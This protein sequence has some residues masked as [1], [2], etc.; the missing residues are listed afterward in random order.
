MYLCFD[1][2][3]KGFLA[4]CQRFISLDGCFLKGLCKGEL[5]TALGRDANDQMYPIAWCIVE[6]ESRASWDCFL[7]QLQTDL[8]IADGHEWCFSLDQQKGLVPSIARS[9]FVRKTHLR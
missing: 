4:G 1:T 8:D 9:S 7:E 3:K 6:V 5:L 2:L